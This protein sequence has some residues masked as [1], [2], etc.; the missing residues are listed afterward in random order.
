MSASSNE[1][2]SRKGFNR[3]DADFASGSERCAAWL[4]LPA[5]ADNPPI[6]V[7]GHGFAAERDFRLPAYAEAFASRGYAVLLFDYRG[8]GSSAGSPRQLVSPRRHLADWQAAVDHVRSLPQVDATR[9][10][11][12]GSSFGGGHVLVTAARNPDVAGVIAQVPYVESVSTL[13]RLTPGELLQAVGSGIR[14]LFRA[15][16]GRAPYTVPVYANPGEFAC[17]NTPESAAGYAAMVP[18]GSAWTNACPA[19][20]FLTLPFYRPIAS[21]ARIDAPALLLAAEDDELIPL[22]DVEA[23]AA[24]IR[25]GRIARVPGGHFSVYTGEG[26]DRATGIYLQFLDRYLKSARQNQKVTRTAA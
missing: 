5:G 18:A 22:A 4:Y 13:R 6:V 14:D 7:M 8:F 24:R 21:A 19:R 16:T 25:N 23:C 3:L 9:M 12:W 10:V 26:F 20:I 17:M 15:L 2:S 11:L 1:M